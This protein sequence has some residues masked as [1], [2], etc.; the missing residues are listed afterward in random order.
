MGLDQSLF[1][2]TEAVKQERDACKRFFGIFSE[3]ASRRI[4]KT[5]RTADHPLD[6]LRAF[7]GVTRLIEKHW[8]KKGA[9]QEARRLFGLWGIDVTPEAARERAY[10]DRKT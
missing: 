6:M 7:N 4:S 1:R 9:R 2:L 3:D 10:R 5:A 8:R